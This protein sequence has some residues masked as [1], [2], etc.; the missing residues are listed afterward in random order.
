[1]APESGY[2]KRFWRKQVSRRRLLQVSALGGTG[3]AAA[4]VV[5]CG[6]DD[7]STPTPTPGATTPA[8]TA[9]P[10][11]VPTPKLGG[12]LRG[13]LVG[14]STGNPPSLDANRQLTFLAQIPAAY[15]YSRLVK[16]VPPTP[17]DVGGYPSVPIDFSEVEG[18]ASDGLPEVVDGTV[19]NFKLRDNLNFHPPLSRPVTAED[20]I[21]VLDL[22]AA[23]SPNRGNWL[24]T[25]DSWE[26]TGDKTL[27]ITLRQP[28]APAFP[29]LFGNTDAGP[30]IVPSEVFED[31]TAANTKPIGSGP[32]IFQEWEPDVAIRWL[33]NPDYYDSPRPY[34]D[35]YEA[36]LSGDS[37]VILQNLASENFSGALWSGQLWERGL[38]E[39]P[40]AQF[41]TGPEQVWGGAYFNF[42][43]KPFDDVRV[44]QALSM[45]VDRPGILS[46][47]D[48]PG[49]A[50][51]G[52][53]HI[54]QYAGF[55]IDPINDAATFGENAKYYQR[56]VEGAK[57]LLAEAGYPNGIDLKATTSIVYGA[58]FGALMEAFGASAAEAGF[59]MEFNYAEY[60]G[61]IST[62][63]YGDMEENELGLAPLMGSPMDPHNI[64]F[65][66]FHPASARHNWGPRG[67]EDLP[68]NSPAGDQ[69]LLDLWNAQAAALDFNDRAAVLADVQRNMAKS[70]YLVPWTGLSTAYIY[71]PWM[72]NV[73]LIRGYGF[74]SESA[75]LMWIDKA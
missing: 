39:L 44:R 59:R 1:M 33:R 41:F 68:D 19:F 54:S 6:D 23:E 69:V 74:G 38:S 30:W 26:A 20:V 56:D 2:W 25:V 51:G 66:I 24:S 46:A 8:A 67:S 43:K 16:F 9:T 72:K 75:P 5:G 64:F 61:Y 62:T 50:G 58:G 49:A 27:T 53:T 55:Y 37:E 34:A 52:L 63:F 42:A 17:A 14:L 71:Q 73:R 11:P 21:A 15:H 70:M 31:E 36:S 13:P 7:E 45:S 65:T 60:G 32:W 48:Q 3:I 22:F 35:G 47:L 12:T 29:V 40:D 18:D 10:T 28:F 57:A 4:A